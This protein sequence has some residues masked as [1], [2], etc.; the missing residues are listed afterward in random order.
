LRPILDVDVDYLDAMFK[1]LEARFGTVEI[2][3]YRQLGL[4][5]ADLAAIRSRLLEAQ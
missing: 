4:T 1:T 3:A 2:Y 5:S